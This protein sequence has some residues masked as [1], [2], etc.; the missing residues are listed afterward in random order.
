MSKIPKEKAKVAN[1][2]VW[3][4]R[5]VIGQELDACLMARIPEELPPFRPLQ[6]VL[7]GWDRTQDN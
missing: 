2:T 6:P 3:Q 5:D 7:S 4:L 1:L